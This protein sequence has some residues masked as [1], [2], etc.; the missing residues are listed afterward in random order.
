MS[1]SIYD[2]VLYILLDSL[3][4]PQ[5]EDD[6]CYMF[7][8]VQINKI[9]KAI[10]KA[11]KERELV[12]QYEELAFTRLLLLNETEINKVQALKKKDELIS[13]E[14]KELENEKNS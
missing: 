7:N 6:D 13:N 3:F 12:G 10:R 5:D 2:E 11:Q 8:Y 1:K 9:L 14:I 4:D